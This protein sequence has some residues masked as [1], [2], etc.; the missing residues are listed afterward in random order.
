MR[1]Q[2]VRRVLAASAAGVV[3]AGGAAVGAAGTA[4]AA[5]PAA[6]TGR[7]TTGGCFGHDDWRCFDDGGFGH[8][9]FGHG[10][11]DRDGFRHG[12]F[13]HGGF[14]HHFDHRFDRGPFV[15]IVVR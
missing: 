7:V 9:G 8:G 12:G 10:G 5:A 15:I 1:A 3:M 11:F 2:H 14:G 4:V 13:G 6:H